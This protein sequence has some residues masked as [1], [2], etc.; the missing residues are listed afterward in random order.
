[1]IFRFRTREALDLLR[2]DDH[3]DEPEPE[4]VPAHPVTRST[5]RPNQ[6][7]QVAIEVRIPTRPTVPTVI[8]L[9]ASRSIL[10]TPAT[11][12]AEVPVVPPDAPPAVPASINDYRPAHIDAKDVIAFASLRIKEYYDSRHKTKFFQVSDFINLRLYRGYR[13]PVITS[14]KIE[15]QLIDLF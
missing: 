5:T 3:L 11:P 14:R 8:P 6:E 13:V 2:I 9:D 4:N 15:Q 12:P 7:R 1:M 10:S